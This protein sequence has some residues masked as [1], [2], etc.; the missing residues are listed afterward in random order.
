MMM[1]LCRWRMAGS[2]R[3]IFCDTTSYQF[4]DT[5]PAYV[6]VLKYTDSKSGGSW[7]REHFVYPKLKNICSP[8]KSKPKR[9]DT[10]KYIPTLGTKSVPKPYVESVPIRTQSWTKWLCC[11]GTLGTPVKHHKMTRNYPS[12]GAS[13]SGVLGKGT[14]VSETPR[15]KA[16]L[17]HQIYVG[18]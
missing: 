11:V 1:W 15:R 2:S 17:Q 3:Q 4:Y 16:Y 14:I 5:I 8:L 13:P 12:I 7:R 18:I 6:L 9:Y 10:Q